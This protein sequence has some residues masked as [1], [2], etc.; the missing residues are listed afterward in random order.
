MHRLIIIIYFS[1]L[2]TK[3]MF[4]SK[5][6]FQRIVPRESNVLDI[7]TLLLQFIFMNFPFMKQENWTNMW[8]FYHQ[9]D[10]CHYRHQASPQQSWWCQWLTWRH[11]CWLGC[12][13]RWPCQNWMALSSYCNSPANLE[14]GKNS[15]FWLKLKILKAGSCWLLFCALAEWKQRL[16]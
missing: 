5:V 15:S 12:S 13:H 3:I 9:H 14:L 4:L 16:S 1:N 7:C 6:L 2:A 10:H 8:L 11:W